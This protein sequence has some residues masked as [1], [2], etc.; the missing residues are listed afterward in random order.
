MNTTLHDL[1]EVQYTDLYHIDDAPIADLRLSALRRLGWWTV[2]LVAVGLTL[3]YV[4][5]LPDTIPVSFVFKSERAEDIY[6]FPSAVYIERQYVKNGQHVE[7]GDVLLELSAP[8]IAALTHELASAH[9]NIA[10][11]QQYRTKS[12][13][14][15]QGII[16]VTIERNRE[17]IRLKNEQKGVLEQKWASES[18]KLTYESKEA[19]RIHV[20][21]QGLY[22]SGDISKNDLNQS[23]ANQLRA[24][25][26]YD[27][28]YQTY[29][30][31]IGTLNRQI[32][33][34]EL[35][36]KAQEKQLAKNSTDLQLEGNRLKTAKE[37]AQQK[38]RGIYGNFEL[39]KNNHL[40]LKA[41]RN[42][43]VSF[44][45]EGEKEVAASTTLLKLIYEEAPLYAHTQV[46]SG[47]IGKIQVGQS[48][49]F[50]VDAFPVYEW[51]PAYGE[52]SN[53][54][55]TP[56]E[57]G[58]FNVQIRLTNASQLEKLLRIGLS[59]KADIITDERTIYGHLFRK[60]RKTT[61]LL[62]E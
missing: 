61:A 9:M 39:T 38:I 48:A 52:V 3:G 44:V 10:G 8:D 13:A 7:A 32:I 16:N 1:Q 55:L 27:V 19:A 35:D 50:K 4:I 15:E 22:K 59:G 2:L 25:S 20:A 29:L 60:F 47:Q 30:D 51:G 42:S 34:L 43:I 41:N 37:A 56:D 28:A 18:T 21:N 6:R 11:F 49:V 24:K 45:F 36:I 5:V 62:T 12:A 58:L 54:S 17:E 57:K 40:V 26:A 23:E 31:N 33:S 53:V 14:S 46:T